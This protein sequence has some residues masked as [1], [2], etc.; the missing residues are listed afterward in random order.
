MVTKEYT[1][2]YCESMSKSLEDKLFFTKEVDIN[3]YDVIV[4]FGCSDCRII[5]AL[6]KRLTNWR[7]VLIGIDKNECALQ[8]AKDRM[9]TIN[10]KIVQPTVI[11]DEINKF[12][13]TVILTTVIND[14]INKLLQKSYNMLVIFS[15]VLHECGWYN[16]DVQFLIRYANTV[17]IRDMKAPMIKGPIDG[18]TRARIT[19]SFPKDLLIKFEDRYGRIDNTVNL[20]RYFLMYKWTENWDNELR[21][22]YFSVPWNDIRNEMTKRNFHISYEKDYILPYIKKEIAVKFQ[23]KLRQATHKQIIFDRN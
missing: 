9:T 10:H 15:S 12:H 2:I 4:D 5:E 20:Y 3:N 22:D 21:E 16:S 1:K 8:E 14:E 23:H 17:V 18:T 11:N 7:T 13:H 19:H 6:D